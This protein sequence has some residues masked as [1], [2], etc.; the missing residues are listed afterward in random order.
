[1]TGQKLVSIDVGGKYIHIV[2]GISKTSGLEINRAVLVNTPV[3][4]Y[5]DGRM[6][7]INIIKDA[8]K[9]AYLENKIKTKRVA[10]STQSTAVITRDL[11]MPLMK[12]EELENAV[13][14]EMEQYLPSTQEGYIIEFKINQDFTEDNIKKYKIR[15]AAMPAGIADAYYKL[16]LALKLKPVAL[17]IHSNSV[18]KLFAGA[19]SVNG[20]SFDPDKTY[21]FIDMGSRTTTVNIIANGK[22]ELSRILSFGGREIDTAVAPQYNLSLEKA[23][24]KKEE[25]RL[26]SSSYGSENLQEDE[27]RHILAQQTAEMQKLFHFHTSRGAGGGIQ[28]IFIY[29]GGSGLK[30]LAGFIKSIVNIDVIKIDDLGIIKTKPYMEPG[31]D[32]FVNAAAALIRY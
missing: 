32:H 11:V 15:T 10:F 2:E 17:D 8:I 27:V 13:K 26:D 14:Y 30:G 6:E 31:L 7:D 29:G 19:F 24:K 16:A 18:S 4:S 23:E 1:M 9:T 22:L 25:I 12:A 5:A 20:E 28:T 3:G 21:A